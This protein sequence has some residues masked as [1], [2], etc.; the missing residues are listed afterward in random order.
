MR[1]QEPSA[2]EEALREVG[3]FVFQVTEPSCA[4]YLPMGSAYTS[5]QRAGAGDPCDKVLDSLR[6][7]SYRDLILD[8]GRPVKAWGRKLQA[9]AS[10]TPFT[11]ALRRLQDRRACHWPV[12]QDACATAIS[13]LACHIQ[14]TPHDIG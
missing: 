11:Y 6:T 5:I 3:E 10:V 1:A 8:K 2:T 4:A 7:A 12:T 9:L 14:R 13:N